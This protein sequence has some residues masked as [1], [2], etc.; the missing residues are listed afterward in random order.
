MSEKL[1]VAVYARVSKKSENTC[2]SLEAQMDHYKKIIAENSDWELA[3]LYADAGISGTGMKNRT[4]FMHLMC[5]C[6]SGKI[7]KILVKS[8]SRFARNTVDLLEVVRRLKRMQISVWFEEQKI[9]SITEEG[10]LMLTLMA[11]IAQAE[12]ESISENAKWAIRKSFQK[13]VGNT[14]RRTFGYQW[15]DG[16]MIVIPEEAEVV[17]RIFENFLTGGSHSKMAEKLRMEGVVSA[18]GKPFSASSISFILKNVTYT[19]NT[20]LQKTFIRDPISKK[21]V[22]NS[23]ELPRYLVEHSH[24]AIIDADTFQKVQEKLEKNKQERKFP[25]NRTNENYPFTGKIICGKCG[26]HYTRQLWNTSKKSGK[27]ASW[28]CTGKL[29]ARKEK[30]SAK[31]ISEEK[32]MEFSTAELGL[33]TFDEKAFAAKV[34]YIRV[35][36]K[37]KVTFGMIA[38]FSL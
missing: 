16:K 4:E 31:N 17:R 20:L 38:P 5:D 8:I 18:T 27:K 25:Y 1:K 37:D 11:S 21:K 6:E 15:I 33:E 10:E 26:R 28:V 24:E 7:D 36:D 3:G 35:Y 9:D 13:G 30:C 32:L 23:G 2:H 34:E 29:G 12:S 22:I 14:K 19:G